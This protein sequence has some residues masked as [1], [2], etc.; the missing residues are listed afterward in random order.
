M[1]I[2][3]NNCYN[4]DCEIGMNIMRSQG[5]KADWCITDPP[6]GI[7]YDKLANNR[8]GKQ[9]GIAVAAKRTYSATGWD[10]NR[11]GGGAYSTL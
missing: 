2:E 4:M 3:P 8:G 11:V 7:G 6:Y 10:D 9:F 1:I 5:L